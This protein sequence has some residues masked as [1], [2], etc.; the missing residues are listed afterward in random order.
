MIVSKVKFAEII[1]YSPRQITKWLQDG[2]PAEGT[3]KRGSPLRID[4]AAAVR[5]LLARAEKK[6]GAAQTLTAERQRLIAAQAARAEIETQQLR[7]ELCK[8]ADVML[9]FTEAMQ[10]V[11]SQLDALGGRVVHQVAGMNQPGPI[12][13]LLFNECRRIRA[14]AADALKSWGEPLE[15]QEEA[16]NG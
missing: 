1:G 14:S 5:W 9:A 13:E 16:G 3:G 7:G 8:R 15:D 12:R 10:L 4:T 11:A 2:M 6:A